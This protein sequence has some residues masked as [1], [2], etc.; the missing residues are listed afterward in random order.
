[1]FF[2]NGGGSCYIVSVGDYNAP[3][4]RAAFEAGIASL[5]KEDEPT[6]ILLTDAVNMDTADYYALCQQTLAHCGKMKDRFVILDVLDGEGKTDEFRNQIGMSHL[7]CGQ[8]TRP[9]CTLT[10]AISMRRVVSRSK[11]I[12]L[13]RAQAGT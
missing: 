13:P 12:G 8:P 3:P 9:I 7:M 5:E 4:E 11:T 10:W 2:R 6:L 1:M